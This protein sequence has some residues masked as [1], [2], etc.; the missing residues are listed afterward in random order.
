MHPEPSPA[1]LGSALPTVCIA[2]KLMTLPCPAAQHNVPEVAHAL[3]LYAIHHTQNWQV[4]IAAS[5][6]LLRTQTTTTTCPGK[7]KAAI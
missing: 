7:S 2:N 5:N 4:G 1:L 6:Q 3:R